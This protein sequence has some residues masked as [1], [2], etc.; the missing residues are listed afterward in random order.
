MPGG[1]PILARSV[2][3]GGGGNL[4]SLNSQSYYKGQFCRSNFR[5]THRCV[6]SEAR[7]L[8]CDFEH[9]AIVIVAAYD[10]IAE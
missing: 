2:R 8:R 1:R 4:L 10:G 9:R 6:P 5:I 3:E 7:P